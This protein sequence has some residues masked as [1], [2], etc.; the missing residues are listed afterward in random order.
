MR[1]KKEYKKLIKQKKREW[2]NG[3]IK[4]LEQLENHDP[5]EYW[6]L[7]NEI[8]EK[9]GSNSKTFDLREGR[10][11]SCSKKKAVQDGG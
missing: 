6:K 2:K 10:L 1:T 5:K 4:Q 8:R 9:K 7:L 3:M 11:F